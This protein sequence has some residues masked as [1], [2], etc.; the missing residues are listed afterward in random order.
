MICTV[1]NLKEK[2]FT[3]PR[4]C[5]RLNGG[6]VAGALDRHF[7]A[8]WHLSQNTPFEKVVILVDRR[9][10]PAILVALIFKRLITLVHLDLRD[11]GSSRP[12]EDLVNEE[13]WC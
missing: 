7:C 11:E 8:D 10:I 6:G 12:F 1:K 9:K 13:D 4:F 5:F 3:S 2:S